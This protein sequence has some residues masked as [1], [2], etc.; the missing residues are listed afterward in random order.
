[1]SKS[2]SA[3]DDT[4]RTHSLLGP[5]FFQDTL[6]HSP[7]G[8]FVTSPKDG[9]IFVNHALARM[10]GYDSPTDLMHTVTDITSQIYFQAADRKK[11]LDLVTNNGEVA[12][13][14]CQLIKKDGSRVWLLGTAQVVPDQTGEPAYIRGFV[15]DITEQKKIE[16]NLVRSEQKYRDLVENIN[17][18]IYETN[19]EGVIR[20]LSPS[21]ENILSGAE[22]LVGMSLFNLLDPADREQAQ[23]NWSRV[24]QGSLSPG[25]YKIRVAPEK[26]IWIRTS[27][28]PVFQNNKVASV[29]GV[30]Q[31]ITEQKLAEENLRRSEERYRDLSAMLRLI[32]DNVPDMI[33]AKDL[34]KKYIFTNK[35]ICSG[36]LN[37][38][39]VEEPLGKTD[40][41]FAQR[42]RTRHANNPDWHTFGEICRDTDQTT[43]D[44]RCQQQFDEYGNVQGKFLFLDVH[45]AP[46][47]DKNGDMIGTVGSARD[48]TDY[49]RLEKMLKEREEGFRTISLM[50]SDMV[51]AYDFISEHSFELIW[52]GGAVERISGYSADELLAQ[53]SLLPLLS[54]EDQENCSKKICALRFGESAHMELCLIR[55]DGSRI[56]TE[57]KVI[58]VDPEFSS[59]NKRVYGSAVDI[60]ARK[61]AEDALR[62]SE[63]QHR[64]IFQNSPLGMILFDSEGTIIDCNEPFE[65][66]MGAPRDVLIGFNTAGQSSPD[67]QATIKKALQG[68]VAV[69]E[70]EY[71]S[72]N[73]GVTRMLRVNFNPIFPQPP[74]GVIATLEDI[75]E[76]KRMEEAL[77]EERTILRNIL[78]DILA[79]YWDWDME[80]MHTYLSPS[81]KHMFG[82]ED[83]EL[84]NTYEA[85]LNLIVPE[86][87]PMIQSALQAHIES[88][89]RIA[90]N[91]EVRFRHKDGHLVWVICAGRVIRWSDAGQAL[92]IVGCHI[93][94]SEQK[95]VEAALVL[96][97]KEADA[98]SKAKSEFLANMSHELRTPLNG[99]TGILQLLEMTEL[100]EEQHE[101]IAVGRQ[102]SDRLINLLSDILD[103]SRIEVGVVRI[104]HV[105]VNL[106]NLL[107]QIKDLF[108]STAVSKDIDFTVIVHPG[109]PDTLLGDSTR[110]HQVLT[111]LVGNAF[112]FT[113]Q[114]SITVE[115]SALPG[116]RP[117]RCLVLFAV[118]DTG[119]G[120]DDENIPHLFQSFYQGTSGYARS[121]Q[122]AGLG[123]PIC[124]QLIAL[125]GGSMSVTSEPGHGSTFYFTVP[126]IDLAKNN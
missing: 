20:Y 45:K 67:M 115:V 8:V 113:T 58:C 81:L 102:S 94:I 52:V 31:D 68:E 70:Q 78:E 120:I 89:G 66:L 56:W 51:Y 54:P 46:L 12:H 21:A 122:G 23:A 62:L 49:K 64:V 97:K 24:L 30:L 74:T 116:H 35:A 63:Y 109:I 79:G 44:A 103:L 60:T 87:V 69:F 22:Q 77:R 124:S 14:E 38:A 104:Q 107:S 17:D 28:R 108:L 34:N 9:I 39:D 36:L 6:M 53:K 43:M 7:L 57:C 110:L 73:G 19:L 41:F 10:L 15:T 16:E 61:E 27:S 25:E 111:N 80:H 117:H 65:R 82:Y 91:K 4:T 3:S 93:D 42:E 75:G 125:M 126:F 11:L 2:F 95:A 33:W 123:L 105:P 121:H 98:A 71:T 119:I 100:D 118:H 32:C 26:I 84:P 90:L 85:W 96:A 83:H 88:L 106:R 48:V 112:K 101:Y 37:A 50:T 76:R 1:M 13:Q 72:I 18:V 59:A 47:L 99:I 5:D 114:G 29:I 55:K 40:M 86:D 92:R